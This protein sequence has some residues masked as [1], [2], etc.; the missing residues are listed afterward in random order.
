[1]LILKINQI[2]IL[3]FELYKLMMLIINTN[4]NNK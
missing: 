2:I 3:T 4:I 1:M